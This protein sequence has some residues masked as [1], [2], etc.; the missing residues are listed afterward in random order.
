M[1][2]LAPALALLL[3]QPPTAPEDNYEPDPAWKSLGPATWFDAKGR[4]LILRGRVCLREGALEHLLC[5]SRTKEHESILATDAPPKL[6]HAGLLLTGA[7]VGRPVSF[8]PK[9]APPAGTAI[10]IELEWTQDGQPRK[11]NARDWIANSAKK[12]LAMDWVFAGSNTYTDPETKKT[13]YGADDGDL[14]TVAN[15][16]TSLL[17]IPTESTASDADRNYQA[18]T[19][20][21][22]PLGT[23]VTIRLR[24]ILDKAKAGAKA[25]AP[26]PSR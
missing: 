17:D 7:E 18:N 14:V 22:P 15:F 2:A 10:R 4:Q 3:L 6:I 23:F 20:K 12:P 19:E 11:A 5:K 9:F 13:Y 1:L 26:P 21:I 25:P 24:P 16:E 8:T